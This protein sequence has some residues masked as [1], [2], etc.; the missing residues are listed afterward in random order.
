MK[1]ANKPILYL[2]KFKEDNSAL[3]TQAS[4][5]DDSKS[6][7]DENSSN[8]LD[9]V[10]SGIFQE[11]NIKSKNYSIS[12]PELFKKDPIN[13]EFEFTYEVVCY[14]KYDYLIDY[15]TDTSGELKSK[16]SYVMSAPKHLLSTLLSNGKIKNRREKGI[17]NVIWSIENLKNSALKY[18]KRKDYR[19]AIEAYSEVR[20]ISQY[21]ITRPTLILNG[22]N[23]RHQ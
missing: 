10:Y 11:I 13:K 18:Y 6:F 20:S 12:I 1:S 17:T 23:T 21:L 9:S 14:S 19:K 4:I 8:D 16:A 22:L 3:P 2:N 7:G 5:E 15:K